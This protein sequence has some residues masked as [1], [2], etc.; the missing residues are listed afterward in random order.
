VIRRIPLRSFLLAA[1]FVL[2]LASAWWYLAPTQL[3]GSTRYVITHGTSMEPRFH[4]GDLA[5]VRPADQYKVGEIVA[6]WSTM[7][8]TVVL[9]R[10]IA[11]HGSHFVFKGDNNN[12]IDPVEPTRP[13]LVGKLWLHLPRAGAWL[14][15][16][17]NPAVA[18]VLCAVL[19]SILL[20]GFREQ[21]RRG[22]KRPRKGAGGAGIS[23][24]NGRNHAMANR[25]N[26][27]AAFIAA[28]CAAAICLVAAVVAFTRPTD[29]V[30]GVGTPY[31]QQVTFGYTAHVRPGLV[32]PTGTL[33]TGQPIFLRLI[34]DLD[35]Q[36]HYQ[37]TSRAQSAIAGTEEILLHVNGP[38]GWHRN[39]VLVPTTHFSG[40]TTNTEVPLSL[41]QVESFLVRISSLIGAVGV[42]AYDIAVEPV[43]HVTGTVAAQPVHTTFSP[44]LTFQIQGG[45]L[46]SSGASPSAASAPG[47][48]AEPT[49][50]QPGYT[51]SQS[52]TVASTGT[53]ANTLTVL[54]A[55]IPVPAL[56]WLSLLGLILSVL[57]AALAYMRRQAEPFQETAHIQSQYGHM[58][59]PIVAGEDLGWPAVDVPT[60]KA[61]AKLAESG[62]RLILH[63]RSGEVD[64]YMVNDEGTVYRYQVRPSKVVWGEWSEATTP[65][66]AAA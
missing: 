1:A 63:S 60:I 37:L 45:Q 17:H 9:H 48:D 43:V 6:Y 7:L 15:L 62:Q 38:S 50:S 16:L 57:A 4:T 61:L 66:R 32:Y 19:G 55:S 28:A 20:F 47:P 30:S 10:I 34:R 3:G 59:V 40:D 42:G 25:F 64:T 44:L 8:H 5:I 35:I 54:G 65:V 56:R 21:R 29:R 13:E 11:V 18:A 12:F 52:G 26:F 2:V 31:A 33:T 49:T 36:V 51:T 24:V 39:L 22:R 46:A 41:P 23:S 14:D 58:I 53:A 27:S